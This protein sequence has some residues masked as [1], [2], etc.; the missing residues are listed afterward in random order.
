MD[1]LNNG[2]VVDFSQIKDYQQ[3]AKDFAEGNRELEQLLLNCFSRGIK[4]TACCGG[5]EDKKRKPY[6][7]FLYS[8]ENEQLIYALLAKLK[9]NEFD[10]RYNKLLNGKS[11]FFISEGRMFDFNSASTLFNDINSVI[12]SFDIGK[13]YYAELPIDLQKYGLLIKNAENDEFLKVDGRSGYFQMCYESVP[14]GY[15]YAMFTTDSY[16]NSAAEKGKFIRNS[17]GVF[18]SYNLKVPSR[19]M[20]I[21][22]LNSIA[23]NIQTTEMK[24]PEE[25]PIQP[26]QPTKAKEEE[27]EIDFEYDERTKS[28]SLTNHLKVNPGD[29]IE[30]VAQKLNACRAKGINAFA[31]FN[32]VEVNNYKSDDPQQIIDAFGQNLA[33][34]K[35]AYEHFTQMR[36]AQRQQDQLIRQQQLGQS[37]QKDTPQ[38]GGMGK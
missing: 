1:N 31:V 18:P 28:N 5:H 26:Y 8:P 13:D 10:F 7:S 4:T 30:M 12:D 21:Q 33:A 16:Y 22:G 19:E 29:T 15:E 23:M 35:K 37:S 11:F 34:Q 36:D 27:L 20:A 14:D 17:M 38:I 2:S 9:D 3:A 32:G 24:P 25:T 6:I